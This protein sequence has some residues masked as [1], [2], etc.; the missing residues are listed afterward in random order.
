MLLT[1]SNDFSAKVNTA[2]N[3]KQESSRSHKTGAIKDVSTGSS[4]VTKKDSIKGGVQKTLQYYLEGCIDA[5]TY[6]SQQ[7]EANVF[8]AR[9]KDCFGHILGKFSPMCKGLHLE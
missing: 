1:F 9:I 3:Y 4:F 5:L 7:R 2:R 6:D 8:R